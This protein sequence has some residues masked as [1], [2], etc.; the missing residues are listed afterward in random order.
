MD[1]QATRFCQ[2]FR[3]S[4]RR[5]ASLLPKL[6]RAI[7]NHLFDGTAIIHGVSPSP[8]QTLP[9]SIVQ[10]FNWDNPEPDQAPHGDVAASLMTRLCRRTTRVCDRRTLQETCQFCFI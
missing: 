3:L 2:E 5:P 9:C 4:P 8:L 1:H 6:T 10:G 7:A